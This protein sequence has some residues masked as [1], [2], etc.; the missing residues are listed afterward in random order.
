MI[1][2]LVYEK[3]G[4]YMDFISVITIIISISS[5]I[6]SIKVYHL[7]RPKI[8]VSFLGKN[9]CFYGAT[10]KIENGTPQLSGYMAGTYIRIKNPSPKPISIGQISLQYLKQ[11]YQ[12]ADPNNKIHKE[13][14]FYYPDEGIIN[15]NGS[16]IDYKNSGLYIPLVLEAY[17]V[18]D[19]MCLFIFFPKMDYKSVK[20]TL[21]IDTAIGKIKKH[22]KFQLYDKNFANEE[23]NGVAQF[24]ASI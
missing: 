2:T 20:A 8:K 16:C 7:N 24:M 10:K 3:V 6:V 4:N 1:N 23:Y 19:C 17:G 11:K 18:K 12:L 5:L 14:I 21:I 22:A 9:S 15:W 13:V